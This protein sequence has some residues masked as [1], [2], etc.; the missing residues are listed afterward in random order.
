ML[1]KTHGN[2][3]SF[4]LFAVLFAG[5]ALIMA[6]PPSRIT[7]PVDASRTVVAPGRVHH[8]AQAQFDQGAVDPRKQLNY[9][10]MLMKP[11]AA[12]QTGLD[13]L[14]VDQQNPS[15][16]NFRQWLT[17]E[18]FGSRFGLNSSD[19]SKVVAWLTAQ[20]FSVDHVARSNN[21]VAF[22]GSAEKVST[23]LHTPIHQF[24]VNGKMHF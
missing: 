13:A 18:Q 23:A 15:S 5:A 4:R 21:W 17:P 19:Q 22:S 9:M 7:R 3:R 24:Q 2:S 10:V 1:Q 8:L 11:S 14:L 6:A 20:G 12:Q 16:K